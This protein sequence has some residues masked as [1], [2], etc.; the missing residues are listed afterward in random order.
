MFWQCFDKHA[1]TVGSH[2]NHR[3]H[4]LW[5]VLYTDLFLGTGP[6]EV[7]SI[8]GSIAALLANDTYNMLSL[9]K[10]VCASAALMQARRIGRVGL[11]EWLWGSALQL[12]AGRGE[13]ANYMRILKNISFAAIGYLG[14]LQLHDSSNS[15]L[16]IFSGISSGPLGVRIHWLRKSTWCFTQAEAFLHENQSCHVLASLVQAFVKLRRGQWH[17]ARLRHRRNRSALHRQ[18]APWHRQRMRVSRSCNMMYLQT[19]LLWYNYTNINIY[20]S[21]NVLESFWVWDAVDPWLVLSFSL[22]G[23]EVSG[24]GTVWAMN[25]SLLAIISTHHQHEEGGKSRVI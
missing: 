20:V 10:N 4:W 8:C 5:L 11:M 22:Q 15:F 23:F 21:C 16:F 12:A 18:R 7:G 17:S 9:K 2:R 13:I 25:L 1:A 3:R 19:R 24:F 14:W 6:L